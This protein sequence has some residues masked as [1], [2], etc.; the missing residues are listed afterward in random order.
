MDTLEELERALAG[1]GGAAGAGGA[2]MSD[3]SLEDME[4]MLCEL[5]ADG[6]SSIEEMEAILASTAGAG[7]GAAGSAA[8]TA[9]YEA[10][11][12]GMGP[13][14]APAS[15]P[16]PAPE[17]TADALA[18]HDADSPFVVSEDDVEI[19]VEQGGQEYLVDLETGMVFHVVPGADSD[20]AEVGTWD[21]KQRRIVFTAQTEPPTTTTL[22][23]EPEP[24]PRAQPQ[25]EPEPEPQPEP[26]PEPEPPPRQT[27]QRT[28]ARASGVAAKRDPTLPIVRSR[29]AAPPSQPEPV[30]DPAGQQRLAD[31]MAMLLASSE[32]EEGDGPEER[33]QPAKRQPGSAKPK[34][35]VRAAAPGTRETVATEAE[36]SPE[37]ME[38]IVIDFETAAG[39]RMQRR[40]DTLIAEADARTRS[41]N[42]GA[43]TASTPPQ[44]Q[45]RRGAAARRGKPGSAERTEESVRPAPVR[46]SAGAPLPDAAR[47]VPSAPAPAPELVPALPLHTSFGDASKLYWTLSDT[48]GPTVGPPTSGRDR[49]DAVHPSAA[50]VP[51]LVLAPPCPLPVATHA[52]C[53]DTVGSRAAT[54]RAARQEAAGPSAGHVPTLPA[55]RHLAPPLRQPAARCR[56]E[57]AAAFRRRARRRAERRPQWGVRPAAPA[58]SAQLHAGGGV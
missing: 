18:A 48:L 30:P 13:A 1:T 2:P 44:P 46:A 24:E 50:R 40:H 42:G 6:K 43:G 37:E 57:A 21:A 34:P 35:D 8:D 20:P 54:H 29:K 4:A 26:E 28:V 38:Q 17:L 31:E 55:Q 10:F 58:E 32:E 39:R 12:Q 3:K 7:G 33:P 27:Q 56:R 5:T 53:V 14:D 11:L 45:R 22:Q 23:P 52:V 47:G 25:P 19:V 15:Q 49:I 36:V 51:V 16:A 41:S 9:E